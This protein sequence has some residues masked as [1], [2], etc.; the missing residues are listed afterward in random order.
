MKFFAILK[1]TWRRAFAYKG[2]SAIYLTLTL[3]NNFLNIAIWSVAYLNPA[4]R[5]QETFST[6]ITYFILVILFNHIVHSF[7]MGYMSDQDIKRGELS[8]YLLKPF[9][10][11]MYQILLEIPWR[12]IQFTMSLPVILLLIIT[13]RNFV[14]FDLR[15]VIGAFMLVPFAYLLSFFIQVLFASFTFWVEDM[16]GVGSVLEIATLLFS[17]AGIPIFFFPPALKVISMFLPFQYVLYFPVNLALGSLSVTQLVINMF[18]LLLWVV[19]LGVIVRLIWQR[20]LKV[21]TGEGI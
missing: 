7:S 14:S 12:I 10:Y 1:L 13:Y 19:I 5:A 3:L 16:H 4:F 9:P 21:F 18:T 20:G 11:L 8:I 2:A 15:W 17:G 6:F